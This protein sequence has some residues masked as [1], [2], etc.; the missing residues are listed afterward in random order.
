MDEKTMWLLTIAS[1]LLMVLLVVGGW[2]F[3]DW[4]KAHSGSQ[5]ACNRIVGKTLRRYAAL[6]GHKVLADITL[7]GKDG[8][9]HADFVM[10]GSFGMLV[11]NVARWKGSY[12]GEE[13]AEN[14]TVELRDKKQTRQKMP[15]LLK[16]GGAFVEALRGEFVQQKI[17]KVQVYQCVVI[18]YAQKQDT[19]IYLNGDRA[20][21]VYF[22]KNFKN[23]LSK[24]KFEKETDINIDKIIALLQ[25]GR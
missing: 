16:E 15:N 19:G 7:K 21:G 18:P 12:I 14:W 8:N 25:G 6:R 22:L 5:K 3:F 2:L 9:T 1:M 20:D 23:Y 10:V 13:G 17:Y 11:V 24:S 4:K